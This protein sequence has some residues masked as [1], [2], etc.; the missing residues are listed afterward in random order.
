MYINFFRFE[1]MK[2]EILGLNVEDLFPAGTASRKLKIK[3]YKLYLTFIKDNWQ[4]IKEVLPIMTKVGQWTQVL[5][6]LSI[7]TSSKA[8][9]ALKDI[10]RMIR[11]L[12]T[13]SQVS[14]YI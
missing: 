12:E 14:S 13:R 5:S 9:I 6:S 8:L 10:K 3:K 4:L 2:E 11:D 1:Y 7:V